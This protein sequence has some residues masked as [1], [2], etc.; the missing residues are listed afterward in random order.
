MDTTANEKGYTRQDQ[1]GQYLEHI[2]NFVVALN[3]LYGEN[4]R[5]QRGGSNIRPA[6]QLSFSLA[7]HGRATL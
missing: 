6:G 7:S 2:Q 5:S 4:R 3:G 1:F